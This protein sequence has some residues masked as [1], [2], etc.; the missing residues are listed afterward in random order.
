MYL[1]HLFLVLFNQIH[2][3]HI[4]NQVYAYFH[5]NSIIN[6]MNN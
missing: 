6:R 3:I 5:E 1:N 4:L 2:N